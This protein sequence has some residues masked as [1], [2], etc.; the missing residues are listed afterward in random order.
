[1]GVGAR[2]QSGGGLMELRAELDTARAN[3]RPLRELYTE[4]HPRVGAARRAVEAHEAQPEAL[5]APAREPPQLAPREELQLSAERGGP[6]WQVAAA[7]QRFALRQGDTP[8]A[9]RASTV[10]REY[11]QVQSAV[12]YERERLQNATEELAQ[13]L[14]SSQRLPKVRRSLE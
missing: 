12:T 14:S 2:D 1:Y 8:L 10:V 11:R 3:L 9:R 4:I 5:L 13:V 7:L 6:D